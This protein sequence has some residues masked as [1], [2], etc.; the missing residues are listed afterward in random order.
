MVGGAPHFEPDPAAA[1][2]FGIETAVENGLAVDFH[3]DEVLDVRVQHL[4]ELACQ[5]AKHGMEGRVTASHC[6]SHGLLPPAD[7]RGLAGSWRTAASRS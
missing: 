1:M 4:A 7:Q 5:T 6:V 2:T 3:L